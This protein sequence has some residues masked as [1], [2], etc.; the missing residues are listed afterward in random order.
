MRIFQSSLFR[1]ICSLI[2]GSLII[3]YPVDTTK[4]IVVAIGVIFLLSGTVSC[5]AYYFARKNA[6]EN[7]IT[8]EQGRTLSDG[9]PGYPIVG[10][11]S[12]ILGLILVLRPEIVVDV[13]SYILGAIL[14]LGGLN[15]LGSLISA[16]RYARV[17]LFFWICPSLVLIVGIISLVRPEWIAGATMSVIGWC[18]LLYGVTEMINSWKIYSVRKKIEKLTMEKNQVQK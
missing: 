14:V 5:V 3:M 2:V 15:L 8:D 17:P 10:L 9:M 18:L 7:V 11:G 13:M 1:A 4:W 6:R 16:M 12:A